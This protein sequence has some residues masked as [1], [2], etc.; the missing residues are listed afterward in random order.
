MSTYET[1]SQD[2]DGIADETTRIDVAGGT[3][4]YRIEREQSELTGE[5]IIAQEL[6]DIVVEDAER[7]RPVLNELGHQ[8]AHVTHGGVKR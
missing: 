4:V 3:L 7:L 6:V 8:S 1:E 2:G 5:R